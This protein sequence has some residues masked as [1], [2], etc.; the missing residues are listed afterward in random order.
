MDPS[1]Y[2]KNNPFKKE[3]RPNA[4]LK[5]TVG[6][7]LLLGLFAF[8]VMGRGTAH[9]MDQRNFMSEAVHTLMPLD[10]VPVRPS[11]G[12]LKGGGPKL[13]ATPTAADADARAPTPASNRTRKTT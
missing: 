8:W 5:L 4:Q 12:G 7:L 1:Y 11:G 13:N 2:V 3:P 10:S 6:L 9:A